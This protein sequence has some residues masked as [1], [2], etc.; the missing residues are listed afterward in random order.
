MS[1]TPALAYVI[2]TDGKSPDG[3]H[4]Y[5]DAPYGCVWAVKI[6]G[7]YGLRFNI[8]RP[9]KEDSIIPGTCPSGGPVISYDKGKTVDQNI[10]AI[11]S[12]IHDIL[13]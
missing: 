10:V 9:L 11:A 12:K 1:S 13:K 6:H 5:P 3:R 2:T 4:E 7:V 8:V